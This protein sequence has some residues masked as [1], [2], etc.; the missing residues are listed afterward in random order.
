MTYN[1]LDYIS[2]VV[3]HSNEQCTLFGIIG[4]NLVDPCQDQRART[5]LPAPVNTM[6]FTM[7]LGSRHM[8][9]Y[10]DVT[11]P[12]DNLSAFNV[13]VQGHLAE[14]DTD[15]EVDGGAQI[16]EWPAFSFQESIR[17]PC[18][19]QGHADKDASS[20]QRHYR[21]GVSYSFYI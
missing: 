15:D 21:I 18:P 2:K 10:A 6:R 8:V 12:I 9:T 19:S 11:E 1:C 3:A 7:V 17:Q 4:A 13:R 16:Y 20:R 5:E 14:E